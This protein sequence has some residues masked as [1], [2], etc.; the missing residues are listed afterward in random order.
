MTNPKLLC[1]V[2]GDDMAFPLVIDGKEV[3]MCKDCSRIAQD[4]RSHH[5]GDGVAVAAAMAA[6]F[7]ALAHPFIEPFERK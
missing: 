1:V 5:F 7:A 2:C 4:L 3:S 6:F